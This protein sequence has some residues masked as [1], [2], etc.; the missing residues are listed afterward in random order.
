M[1][2]LTFPI[3]ALGEHDSVPGDLG[4][5]QSGPR[6]H[7]IVSR[8]AAVPDHLDASKRE[9]RSI[10]EQRR[11]VQGAAAAISDSI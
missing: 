2:A 7:R 3:P 5:T 6:A 9:R 11:A 8:T 10:V 4:L 1:L